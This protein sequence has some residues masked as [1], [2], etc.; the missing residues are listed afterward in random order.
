MVLQQPFDNRNCL[1]VAEFSQSP[2]RILT[3]EAIEM[4]G[5]LG[6]SRKGVRITEIP[7]SRDQGPKQIP[8]GFPWRRGEERAKVPGSF[9]T[10]AA[11]QRS[12]GNR[13]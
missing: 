7:Q 10:K 3:H 5:Q 11:F 4:F 12:K 6:Q 13:P 9:S 8:F 1:P 2:G